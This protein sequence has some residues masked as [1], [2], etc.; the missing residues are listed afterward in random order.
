MTAGTQL[1]CLSA[2]LPSTNL[3]PCCSFPWLA[4]WQSESGTN[5]A[6]AW[7]T[8][9]ADSMASAWVMGGR[10]PWRAVSRKGLMLLI[11]Y[12][13]RLYICAGWSSLTVSPFREVIYIQR[14]Q[15][16]SAQSQQSMN[17]VYTDEQI[18]TWGILLQVSTGSTKKERLVTYKRISSS[19]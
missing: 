3:L 13:M 2:F 4:Y 7:I 6:K 9:V 5:D 12:R 11:Q 8:R 10:Q 16:I 18:C 1:L 17:I 19:S 15:K 14:A